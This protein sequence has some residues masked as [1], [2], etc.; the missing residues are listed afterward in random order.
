[1]L[2][3]ADDILYI[4]LVIIAHTNWCVN[5]KRA[6]AQI[7]VFQLRDFVLLVIRHKS[8]FYLINR[9]LSLSQINFPDIHLHWTK[10][11]RAGIIPWYFGTVFQK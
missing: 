10:G 9:I 2:V 6:S 4:V 11:S 7:N 5:E 3:K 1:M 8:I